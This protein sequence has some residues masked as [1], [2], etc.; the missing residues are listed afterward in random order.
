LFVLSE[1]V[2]LHTLAASSSL[3]WSL[4][5]CQHNLTAHTLAVYNYR[6]QVSD[7]ARETGATTYQTM[8]GW[9]MSHNASIIPGRD[10]SI[11]LATS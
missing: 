5:P 10:T 3:A 11:V 2:C 6:L 1:P 9:A 8:L 7:I 4:V